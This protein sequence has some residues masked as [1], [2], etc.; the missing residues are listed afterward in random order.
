MSKRV[1]T[2]LAAVVAL[3]VGLWFGGHPSWLPGPL[4]SVFVSQSSSQQLLDQVTNLI[5]ANYYRTVNGTKLERIAV[6]QGLA[7]AV[8]TL[9][10]PYSHYYPPAEYRSFQNAITPQ[11]AG[12]GVDVSTSEVDG[13]TQIL[14]VFQG[15]PAARAGLQRGDVIIAVNGRSLKG[16]SVN[17]SGALIRGHA[18]TRV[19]L[20][21]R[22]GHRT[23]QR[24]LTRAEVFVPV[25]ASKLLSYR[26][27]KLGYL[28]FTQ[29]AQNS[30]AE[31]RTQV[32]RMLK[33]GA[34]GLVLDLRDNPG[35]LVQ[36]AIGVAS[37]FIP[38]GT[39]VTTRGRNQPT[40]AYSALGDALAPKIPLV[41]LVDRGTASSAEIVTGALKDHHRA[42]VIGTDTYGKGV[43]QQIQQVTGGGALEITVGEYFTPNGQNLGAGGVKEG[44]GITP[45]IYV[46]DN[47]QSP[48]RKALD[49]AEKTL[50]H[51][52]G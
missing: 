27:R 13:G 7:A 24:T 31:L 9:G 32:R 20:T 44:R 19:R 2:S 47:P 43:F 52:L 29:F 33:A 39:I 26:G 51:E 11:V 38:S 23:F 5:S 8:Q 12:I 14:E 15:S 17:R 40:V 28:E 21:I 34:Q 50:Y 10:D 4:R 41:V 16:L 18:G 30:A 35:G 48:G 6:N 37:I 42:L 25:A 3:A 46:Y 1:R 22:R 36:Q 45:N 49:V